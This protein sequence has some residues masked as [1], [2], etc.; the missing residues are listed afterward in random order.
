MGSAHRGYTTQLSW[1]DSLAER[2]TC[3][4]MNDTSRIGAQRW[5]WPP[6]PAKGD[7]WAQPEGRVGFDTWGCEPKAQEA[8][9]GWAGPEHSVLSASGWMVWHRC[10]R[11]YTRRAYTTHLEPCHA[12]NASSRRSR[13][14][15]SDYQALTASGPLPECPAPPTPLVLCRAASLAPYPLALNLSSLGMAE[16][17]INIPSKLPA[18]VLHSL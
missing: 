12:N 17:S 7:I 6:W 13:D 2:Q 5:V 15:S 16:S 4:Q 10:G 1:P 14:L 3:G 11:A 9:W 18:N 8:V